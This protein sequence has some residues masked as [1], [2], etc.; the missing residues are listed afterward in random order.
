M[1]KLRIFLIAI[2]PLIVVLLIGFGIFKS[3]DE[4]KIHII[5]KNLKLIDAN[6]DHN[7]ALDVAETARAQGIEIPDTIINFDTHSDVY[8][9]APIT[10]PDGAQI[11]NW[12]NE[13]LAKN[14]EVKVLYWVMP[15]EEARDE[16]MQKDFKMEKVVGFPTSMQGNSK[17]PEEQVNPNVHK[18]PYVQYFLV[19][20]KNSYV[21]EIASAKDEE[22]LKNPKYKK[23]KIITCTESTLP[24]FK[25]K[26]VFLSVDMDYITNSGFDTTEDWSHNLSERGIEQ[27]TSRFLSSLKNKNIRPEVISLT[28]SPQY[29]PKEYEEQIKNFIE[30]FIYYSNKDDVIKEYKRQHGKPYVKDGGKKYKDV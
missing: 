22:K 29:L 27:A 2:I 20:T 5:C 15:E 1:K 18:V 3:S 4:Q 9:Y 24:N 30:F 14:K 17:K 16:T 26:K 23:V 8:N 11:Y 21:E 12:V 28:L 19:N 7:Q 25:N 6:I 13:Y 10:L